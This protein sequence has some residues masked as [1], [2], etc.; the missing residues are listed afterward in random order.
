MK[1]KSSWYFNTE[2]S[3]VTNIFPNEEYKL[4]GKFDVS[5]ARAYCKKHKYTLSYYESLIA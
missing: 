5:V 4:I 1:T 2:S 3:L